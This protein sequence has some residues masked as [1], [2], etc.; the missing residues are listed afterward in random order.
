MLK[1]R[2]VPVFDRRKTLSK[3]RKGT[4]EIRIYLSRN[5]IKYIPLCTIS[6]S[7]WRTYQKSRELATHI[8]KYKDALTEMLFLGEDLTIEN[9]MYHV[10]GPEEYHDVKAPE[11]RNFVEFIREE[12]KYEELKD[13]TLRH[14]ITVIEALERYGKIE[15]IADLTPQNIRDFDHWLRDTGERSDVTIWGYHKRIKIYTRILKNNNLIEVDPYDVVKFK[16]GKS[17]PRT[18]L[19]EKELVLLREIP[20]DPK[21]DRVRDLFVFAAYTGLSYIDVMAFDFK[22]MTEKI[23]NIFYIDG[24]RTKTG[25]Q[26]FT[27]ILTPAMNVLKKYNFVLP[28]ISNQ[29]IND[30]LH[31]IEGICGFKRNL[32]F[33]IA[34]HTFA[35]LALA[36]D[37]PIENVSKMLGHTNIKT[38]QIY[39]K[40]LKTTLQRHVVNF[41]SVIL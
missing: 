18:P 29:K 9:L 25:T 24:Q 31:V 1:E 7:S 15:T 6:Q 13:G 14:K 27:P 23:D 28:I 2:V 3:T 11:D 30:Y 8:N 37:I 12:L 39:A 26:F 4:V 20:L 17:K 22:V 40:V 32:T 10:N 36:H 5:S 21:L 41:D 35:T 38:T 16:H 34:R 19:T 33:H